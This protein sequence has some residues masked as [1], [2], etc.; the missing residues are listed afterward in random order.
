M[1]GRYKRRQ[2]GRE[3]KIPKGRQAGRQKDRFFQAD[4]AVKVC[5]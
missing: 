1:K 5:D 4:L 3:N 2:N